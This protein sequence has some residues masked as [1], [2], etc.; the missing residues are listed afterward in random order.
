MREAEEMYLRALRG[1]EEEWGP[2]HISTLD[3]VNNLANL[4][5]NQ[6][7]MQEAE[8]MYLR[9]LEGYEKALGPEHT[10]TLHTINNLGSLYRH[11]G[12]LDEAEKMYKRALA[13]T[14]VNTGDS[15]WFDSLY[16]NQAWTTYIRGVEGR[17]RLVSATLCSRSSSSTLF[18]PKL[19][20]SYKQFPRCDA[21]LLVRSD[22]YSSGLEMMKMPAMPFGN[23][24]TIVMEYGAMVALVVMPVTNH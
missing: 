20:K 15:S 10:S 4:Y 19:L 17:V 11:Q 23:K 18:V 6:G 9:A 22:V 13:G 5:R 1:K 3:T 21:S 16:Y 24:S 2:K 7:K 8:E 14:L 12:K